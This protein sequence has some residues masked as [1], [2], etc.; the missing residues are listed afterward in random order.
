MT[1]QGKDGA[2]WTHN[3]VVLSCEGK[4]GG[5]CLYRTC[6]GKDGAVWPAAGQE[7]GHVASSG[8]HKQGTRVQVVGHGGG[9]GTQLLAGSAIRH[10]G[11][12]GQYYLSMLLLPAVSN[13]NCYIAV[14]VYTNLLWV[15]ATLG[16]LLTVL[17]IFTQ[18]LLCVPA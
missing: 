10:I 2:V 13:P 7:V 18:C 3:D 16:R 1:S 4:D 5:E 9:A 8:V 15:T 17:S 14:D 12:L 11:Q 6:E